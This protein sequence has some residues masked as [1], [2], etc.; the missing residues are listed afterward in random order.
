MKS[1]GYSGN[2]NILVMELLGKSLEDIFVAIPNKKMS[3][4]CVCNIGY[5]MV[6][7]LQYVHNKHIIHRDI[8]PDNFV[9]GTGD[10]AKRIYLLDFGLAKKYRSSTTLMHYP[11]TNK[12]KLT[13]TARYASINALK[14]L[15]QSRRD[16]LEAVGYVL[17]YFLRG[18][19]PWQGLPVKNKEDRYQK[20]ME[21]KRNTTPEELC[22]DFPKEFEE[23]IK[24]TRKL[25]YEQDPNY[26][27]LKGLFTQVLNELG[28]EMDYY[29]DWNCNDNKSSKAAVINS[30]RDALG[31]SNRNNISREENVEIKKVEEKEPQDPV[32]NKVLQEQEKEHKGG[33]T[34]VNNYY[35]NV[36][37]IVIN[38]DNKNKNDIIS[39]INPKFD[40]KENIKDENSKNDVNNQGT[41]IKKNEDNNQ[42]AN[43]AKVL[44]YDDINQK[45][46]EPGGKN[47]K[48]I[49]KE[50]NKCCI[51][52]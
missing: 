4:R 38:S 44:V 5:Q 22:K 39:P 11:M 15:E 24:Y 21:K 42:N 50:N 31:P 40:N 30:N 10:N 7:I 26:E 9:V 43:K 35:N 46:N 51:I 6:T 36:Q 47:K 17:M 52:M 20:I 33:I 3:V 19:L 49:K 14:G 8:K 29:Y 25:E 23:Y 41:E 16:D 32:D 18:S 12:K 1:Y 2:Y 34:V 13:G 28:C 45:V 37:N 27:Y 48:V